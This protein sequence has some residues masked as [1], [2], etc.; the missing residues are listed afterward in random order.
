M[1]ILGP[2]GLGNGGK[3]SECT[4]TFDFLKIFII[5]LNFILTFALGLTVTSSKIRL[6]VIVGPIGYRP[7]PGIFR[8]LAGKRLLYYTFSESS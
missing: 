6:A 8:F 3:D 7:I 1:L 4:V 5:S 2:L